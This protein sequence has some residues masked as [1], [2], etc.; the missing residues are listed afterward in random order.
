MKRKK[1]IITCRSGS[2]K[3]KVF[4]VNYPE[5]GYFWYAIEGGRIVHKC[6]G[7]P[8]RSNK[9]LNEV[10]ES[11]VFTYYGDGNNKHPDCVDTMETLLWL[12]KD[13]K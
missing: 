9:Q 10:C 3:V 4:L 7:E 2:E 12:L 11:E 1:H 8:F 6:Y 13:N 5:K